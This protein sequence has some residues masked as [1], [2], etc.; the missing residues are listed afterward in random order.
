L[1]NDRKKAHLAGEANP[2]ALLGA[3]PSIG[4]SKRS[5]S[6]EEEKEASN[7]PATDPV[8]TY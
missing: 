5:N 1:S 8:A 4:I 7:A 2:P 3:P 6:A